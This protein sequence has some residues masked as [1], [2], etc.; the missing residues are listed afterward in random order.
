MQTIT[1]HVKGMSCGHCAN[2]IQQALTEIGAKGQVN[3]EQA[4]VSATYEESKISVSAI[5]EAI[6][7]QGYEVVSAG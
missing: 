5:K 7:E 6:E 1:L 4:V 2:A 3:L